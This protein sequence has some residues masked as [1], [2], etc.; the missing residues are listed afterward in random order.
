M[1]TDGQ[2]ELRDRLVSYI[3]HNASKGHDAV[4]NVIT[5]EH[6]RLMDSI[7]GLSLEQATFTFAPDEWS[8]LETMTHMVELKGGVIQTCE[9]LARGELPV[10]ASAERNDTRMR[11]GFSIP[12]FATPEEA[13]KAASKGHQALAGFLN[14]VSE[15]S[16]TEKTHSHP[17]FGSMNCLE[18][19]VYLRIHDGDHVGQ[20]EKIKAADGFPA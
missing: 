17:F 15:A 18:W 19:A 7:A 20:I 8:V 12:P 14:G 16:N 4:L 13:S 6:E 5:K 3:K 1:V 10:R 11:D 2:D 9:A